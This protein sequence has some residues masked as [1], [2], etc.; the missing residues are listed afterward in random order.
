M[1]MKSA[2]TVVMAVS[3]AT[4]MVVAGGNGLRVEVR[5]QI[6]SGEP[7]VGVCVAEQ[8]R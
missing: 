4:I 1:V 3:V 8:C 5:T 6:V 2:R 7:K